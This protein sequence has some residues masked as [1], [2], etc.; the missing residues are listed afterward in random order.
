MKCW[1]QTGTGWWY[2]VL[3]AWSRDPG[4]TE[5]YFLIEF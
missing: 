3:D 5:I 2:C 1:K 4:F